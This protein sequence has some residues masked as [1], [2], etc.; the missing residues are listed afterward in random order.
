[1]KKF[2]A[3]IVATWL[4]LF[5]SAAI[6]GTPVYSEELSVREFSNRNGQKVIEITL[7]GAAADAGAGGSLLAHAILR[8]DN[9]IE[10]Q[11]QLVEVELIPGTAGAEPT[12]ANVSITDGSTVKWGPQ[13]IDNSTADTAPGSVYGGH[14]K[15]GVFPVCERQWYLTVGDIGD[16]NTLKIRL[17]FK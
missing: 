9:I 10:K 6:A 2:L 16:A 1:M 14:D 11:M 13:A 4:L 8:L 3:A 12:A 7:T 5:A 17:K 15:W